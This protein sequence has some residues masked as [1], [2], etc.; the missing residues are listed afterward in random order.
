VSTSS[1]IGQ[2]AGIL[3]RPGSFRLAPE[4]PRCRSGH[5]AR[6]AADRTAALVAVLLFT[7]ARLSGKEPRDL[8]QQRAEASST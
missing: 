1:S 8:E 2:R 7:G 6:F 5:G 3:D 4:R